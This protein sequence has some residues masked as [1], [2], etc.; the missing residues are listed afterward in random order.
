MNPDLVKYLSSVMRGDAKHQPVTHMNE[1]QSESDLQLQDLV[2]D[3]FLVDSTFA[4]GLDEV[5]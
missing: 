1:P 3:H 2:K 5:I 4:L